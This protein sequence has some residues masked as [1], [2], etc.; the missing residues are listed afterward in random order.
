LPRRQR[1]TA[2]GAA[3]ARLFVDSGAWIALVSVRDQ[4][5]GEAEAMF[6][7]ATTRRIRLLTTNLVLAETHRLL[8]HRAGIRP[9]MWALDRFEASPLLTIVFAG[10]A[11]HRAARAWLERLGDQSISYT[12][13]VS[14]AVMDT[15]RC[16]GVMSFDHDFLLAGFSL[17][18]G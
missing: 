10:P 16:G 17:W 5:H 2:G 7:S 12:D 15:A 1:P 3:P 6:R 8:L 4:H 18:F 11:H 14:F 9:A 13:A